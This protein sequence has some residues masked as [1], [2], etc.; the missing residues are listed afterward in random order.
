MMLIMGEPALTVPVARGW[1]HSSYTRCGCGYGYVCSVETRDTHTRTAVLVDGVIG[2]QCDHAQPW[3]DGV[4]GCDVQYVTDLL[5]GR[6]HVLSLQESSALVVLLARTQCKWHLRV[7]QCTA[8]ASPA[9]PPFTHNL[10]QCVHQLQ[11]NEL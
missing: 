2:V 6:Q 10:M 7:T 3:C 8:H 9:C 1:R 11:L 5:E 4:N